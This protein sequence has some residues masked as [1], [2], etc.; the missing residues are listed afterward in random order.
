M[1]TNQSRAHT[2]TT[3]SSGLSPSGLLFPCPNHPKAR[4]QEI[5][6]PTSQSLLKLIKPANP[7]PAYPSLQFF[8]MEATIKALA[9]IFP[10]SVCCLTSPGT[11]PCGL[12][13]MSCPLLLGTVRS[14]LFFQGQLSLGLLASPYLNNNKTYILKHYSLILVIRC[15]CLFF[16]SHLY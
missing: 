15:I 8:S 6:A 9:H 3:S 1:L 12:C 7:K 4:Y 11:S 14:K 5:R 16:K 13:G 2:P 10:G